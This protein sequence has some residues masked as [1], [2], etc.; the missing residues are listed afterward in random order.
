[1]VKNKGKRITTKENKMNGMLTPN[2]LSIELLR[3]T[4]KAAGLNVLDD[5]PLLVEIGHPVMIDHDPEARNVIGFS[6]ALK[7]K[8]GYTMHDYLA[9]VNKINHI[10]VI[11]AFIM[12]EDD[13]HLIIS[14]DFLITGGITKK[15]FIGTLAQFASIA[16]RTYI[17]NEHI[18]G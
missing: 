4:V 2:N 7:F 11:K 12:N 5:D 8:D 3:E 16:L 6:T 9:C 10:R 14:F 18:V 15:S 1:M 17:D 13:P